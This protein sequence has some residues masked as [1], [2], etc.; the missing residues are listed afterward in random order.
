M[1]D[2]FFDIDVIKIIKT[3]CVYAH[4]MLKTLKAHRIFCYFFG[5]QFTISRAAYKIDVMKIIKNIVC[6]YTLYVKHFKTHRSFAISVVLSSQ[7]H[8]P[9]IRSMSWKS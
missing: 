3:Q 7:F 9:L 4:S 5:A 6:L 1:R 8:V 2:L